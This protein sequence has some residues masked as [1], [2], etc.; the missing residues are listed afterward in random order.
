MLRML[1]GG[2]GGGWV[3]LIE[4]ILKKN[5][6]LNEISVFICPYRESWINCDIKKVVFSI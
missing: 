4:W 5:I 6:F 1:S 3:F 2:G